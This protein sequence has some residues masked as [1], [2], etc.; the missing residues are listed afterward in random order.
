M[1]TRNSALLSVILALVS[2]S[3][4]LVSTSLPL[5]SANTPGLGA[6]H[7]SNSDHAATKSSN[8]MKQQWPEP[9]VVGPTSLSLR[10]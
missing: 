9:T 5:V 7:S 2:T 10:R 8:V 1:A 4:P 6:K 3:L